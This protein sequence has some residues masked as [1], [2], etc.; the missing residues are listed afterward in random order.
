MVRVTLADW[1]PGTIL[2]QLR[3]GSRRG[4]ESGPTVPHGDTRLSAAVLKWR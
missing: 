4:A 2:V 1:I 3:V